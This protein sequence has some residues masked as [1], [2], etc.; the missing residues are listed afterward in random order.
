MYSLEIQNLSDRTSSSFTY[1]C[2]RKPFDRVG[3]VPFFFF[4]LFCKQ[5]SKEPERLT[6]SEESFFNLLK[7]QYLNENI[8]Q[9]C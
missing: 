1:F 6:F 3:R 7:L 2:N 5:I 4:C 8:W 9:T